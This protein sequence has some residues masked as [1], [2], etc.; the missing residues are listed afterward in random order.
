M[1]TNRLTIL[2]V[3]ALAVAL[4][5]CPP[6]W[7][8]CETDAQCNTDGHTGVCV[9]GTCQ[10]C[11]KD[12][13]CKAGFVCRDYRCVPKPECTRDADCGANRKCVGEKCVEC[14]ADSDCPS[15]QKCEYNRC[16]KKAECERSSDCPTGKEC[17]AGRCVEA[18]RETECTL[19]R[20]H[21]GFNESSL[22]PEAQRALDQNAECIKKHSRPVTIEGH[23]DERGTVEYNLHLGEKR[24]NS[25]RKYLVGLGVDSG[26]LKTV[27]YGEERP[28]ASGHDESAW[29]ENRRAE[30][31]EK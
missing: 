16:V 5:G 26:L 17:Q 9:N 27:S 28:A 12:T 22:T 30:S 7:P 11:G 23:C 6:A 10:E 20:V 3:A 31:V 13:D 19:G 14:A 1:T 29:A 2:A 8:K 24:A 21:F 15:G 18:V 25:V 4:S